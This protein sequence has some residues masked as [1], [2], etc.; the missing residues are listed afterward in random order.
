MPE[1][2]LLRAGRRLLRGDGRLIVVIVVKAWL[3]GNAGYIGIRG[4]Q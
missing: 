3:A 2:A 1:R 4:Y